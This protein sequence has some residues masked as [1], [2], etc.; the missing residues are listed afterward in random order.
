[1]QWHVHVK[2]CGETF[3]KL[4]QFRFHAEFFFL[5]K[6]KFIK[7]QFHADLFL[8]KKPLHNHQMQSCLLGRN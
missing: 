3:I 5:E 2:N 1:M 7:F 4:I 6:H 8:S